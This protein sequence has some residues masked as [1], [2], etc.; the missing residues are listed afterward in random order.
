MLRFK[1]GYQSIFIGSL[2]PQYDPINLVLS[3]LHESQLETVAEVTKEV[4]HG[5]SFSGVWGASAS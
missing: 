4:E 1:N 3:L 5:E 2:G